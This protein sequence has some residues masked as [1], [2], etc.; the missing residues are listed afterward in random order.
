MRD[1]ANGNEPYSINSSGIAGKIKLPHNDYKK[2]I[3]LG[4]FPHWE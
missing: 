4:V 2:D 3:E 1:N